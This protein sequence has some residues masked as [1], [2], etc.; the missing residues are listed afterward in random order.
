MRRETS[1]MSVTRSR[2]RGVLGLAQ[3]VG[4]LALDVDDDPLDVDQA[5]A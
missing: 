2:R 5:L 3:L 4:E 1:W